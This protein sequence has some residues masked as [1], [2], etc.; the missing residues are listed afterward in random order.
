VQQGASVVVGVDSYLRSEQTA[1]S[2][3]L[4]LAVIAVEV[5]YT[6][7]YVGLVQQQLGTNSSWVGL[8]GQDEYNIKHSLILFD[9]ACTVL[10]NISSI[11]FSPGRVAPYMQC[12]G[13]FFHRQQFKHV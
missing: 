8:M 6:E 7:T 10:S 12:C 11:M 5:S 9:P 4:L 13:I 3:C 2:G 1:E